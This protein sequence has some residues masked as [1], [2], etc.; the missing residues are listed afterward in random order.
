MAAIAASVALMFAL[1]AAASAIVVM[2]QTGSLGPAAGQF[3][4]FGHV[5]A[6]LV[7]SLAYAA[8]GLALGIWLRSANAAIGAV[9]AW[10]VVVQPSIEHI[11]PELH[12]IVLRI[13]DFLPDASTN[14]LV[15]LFG[16][17]NVALGGPPLQEARIVPL[18][19]FLTLGL[20]AAG[21]LSVSALLTMR[22]DIP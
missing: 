4:A 3:P 19:A 10:A 13:Y 22:R 15:N 12:G 16:N 21:C 14:T 5:A 6:A 8:A 17:P 20:Y 2:H 11:A 9:L 1:A 7:L 18:L